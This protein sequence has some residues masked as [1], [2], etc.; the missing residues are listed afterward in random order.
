MTTVYTNINRYSKNLFSA[1]ISISGKNAFSYRQEESIFTVSK[2]RFSGRHEKSTLWVFRKI[3]LSGRQK[4]DF[5]GI[6]KIAFIEPLNNELNSNCKSTTAT[7]TATTTTTKTT[8]LQL[9]LLLLLQLLLLPLLVLLLFTLQLLLLLKH[10]YL[11][12]YLSVFE[13]SFFQLLYP[14]P[15][16]RFFILPGKSDLHGLQKSIF[17]VTTK[18]HL[19][20]FSRK[21]AFSGRQKND[22]LRYPKNR[23]N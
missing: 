7:T 6:R 14:F 20:G 15:K 4:N 17:Q 21:I 22:F 10:S 11:Y 9:L 12:Q 16:K 19:Y 3:S 5:F 13:K 2:N 1:I 18:K 8:L 23:F